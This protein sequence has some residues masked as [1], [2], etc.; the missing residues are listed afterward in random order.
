MYGNKVLAHMIY[1]WICMGIFQSYEYSIWL[2]VLEY[3]LH[4]WRCTNVP[5]CAYQKP[6]V[7]NSVNNLISNSNGLIRKETM[8]QYT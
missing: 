4:P 8:K 1:K 7:A 5:K 2:V 6:L 3:F